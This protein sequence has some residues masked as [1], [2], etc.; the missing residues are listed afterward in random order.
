MKSDVRAFEIPQ[1]S[2]H[3]VLE[4]DRN[5]HRG[6]IEVYGRVKE[7]EVNGGMN[8][9]DLYFIYR[10]GNENAPYDELLEPSSPFNG[11]RTP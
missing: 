5:G 11:E 9:T 8:L 7:R 10:H 6:G 4:V 2:R 3:V 1:T